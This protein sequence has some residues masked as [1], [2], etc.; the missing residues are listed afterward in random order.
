MLSSR[1]SY[2]VF[3]LFC[4]PPV[5]AKEILIYY[6]KKVY[7]TLYTYIYIYIIYRARNFKSESSSQIREFGRHFFSHKSNS[8]KKNG[9]M[10]IAKLKYLVANGDLTTGNFAPWYIY[11]TCSYCAKKWSNYLYHSFAKYHCNTYH[12][13]ENSVMMMSSPFNRHAADLCSEFYEKC[14]LYHSVEQNITF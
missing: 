1:L 8:E 4:V 5:I 11:I 7:L 12:E 2:S 3:P 13:R 10:P 6:D 14:K 9:Q